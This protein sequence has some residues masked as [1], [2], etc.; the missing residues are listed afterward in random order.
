MNL[1]TIILKVKNE[2]ATAELKRLIASGE[3]LL[4]TSPLHHYSE[5]GEYDAA[6]GRNIGLENAAKAIRTNAVD[7]YE[8]VL[9]A[10]GRVFEGFTL[11]ESTL[12]GH[13][14]MFPKT[15]VIREV[16]SKV[17]S[18]AVP[19]VFASVSSIHPEI[20][21]RCY[22]NF[23]AGHFDDVMFDAF[24][25]LENCIRV[26]IQAPLDE[27]G[28]ALVKIAMNPSK[29]LLLFSP[30][31]AEQEAVYQLYRGAFGMLKNPLSHRFLD[32]IDELMAAEAIGFAS[33]LRRLLDRATIVDHTLSTSTGQSWQIE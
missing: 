27:V 13:N 14:R 7:W 12:I 3:G 19:L 18:E 5:V 17:E 21:S 25:A 2:V 22:R 9:R 26:K 1:P 28:L 30:V 23:Q 10:F 33:L 6:R 15:S 8:E 11:P 29:P 4:E 32:S 20:A 24:K 16:L 31:P